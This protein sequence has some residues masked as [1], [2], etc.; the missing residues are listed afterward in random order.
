M[1][2]GKQARFVDEYMLCFNGAEAARR[3]GYS[4][5]TARSIACEN[6]KKPEIAAEIAL[7]RKEIKDEVAGMSAKFY[8]G[9]GRMAFFNLAVLVGKDGY[10]LPPEEWPPEAWA[11]VSK[12][13]WQQVPGPIDPVTRKRSKV[14]R[15]RS[16]KMENKLPALEMLG[17]AAG[18]FPAKAG[19]PRG[20]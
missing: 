16:I 14:S 3:A 19:R 5:K 8:E 15:P 10:I 17:R 13:T 12:V 4:L 2:T 6:L 9:L 7:R 18:L 20:S 11:A 1:L